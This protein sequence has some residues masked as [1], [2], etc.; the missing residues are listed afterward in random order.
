MKR[1][2]APDTL[3]VNGDA[4]RQAREARGLSAADMA[5]AVTLS[6][7]QVKALEEGG[8]LPFYTASHKL[9]AVRKLAVALELPLDAVL[10]SGHEDTPPP[11]LAADSGAGP[12]ARAGPRWPGLLASAAAA[13]LLIVLVTQIDD[14]RDDTPA[15]TTSAE[16]PASPAGESPAAPPAPAAASPEASAPAAASPAAPAGP[17]SPAASP[18]TPAPA[19][20]A[21]AADEVPCEL[22][23]SA[24]AIAVSPPYRRKDDTRP[25]FSTESGAAL[26]IADASGKLQLLRLPPGGGRY[27]SGTPPFLVRSDSLPEL[28]IY[29][30]GMRVRVPDGVSLARL[31]PTEVAPPEPGADAS[32][33]DG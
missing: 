22:N 5:A 14:D 7:E 15:T 25:Y 19:S 6:R 24:E 2:A 26:C 17:A 32:D 16:P 12:V 10:V 29:M 1:T 30:Q 8:N 23:A 4:L 27:V 13:V 31:V 18:E 20:A 33:T 9:L 21:S 28:V 3:V 11:E